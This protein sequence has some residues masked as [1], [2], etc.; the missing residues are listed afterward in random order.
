MEVLESPV[1]WS[2]ASPAAALQGLYWLAS[3]AVALDYEDH[4]EEIHTCIHNIE[5][6]V[7]C[8]HSIIIIHTY[9]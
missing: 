9:A 6:S 3:H 1:P 8:V 4:G 7:R 2:R 5:E